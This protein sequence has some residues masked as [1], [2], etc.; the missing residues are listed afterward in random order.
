MNEELKVILTAEIDKLKQNLDKSKK[1]VQQFA[2][3]GVDKFKKFGEAAKKA[4]EA[5]KKG[6]KVIATAVTAAMAA[7]VALAASTEEFRAN[8]A[9]L[10]TAFETAGASAETAAQV[11]K[12]LYRV[13]GDD[14][15]AVEA[16]QH[17]AKLTNNQQ[18]LSEWTNICQGVYAT[19][20]ESLPIEGL[21]EAVNHTAKLGEV[22]GVLADALE[23]S[24]VNV[25]DFNAK[26][27]QCNTE[28]ER[29][30]LIRTTL[31]ELYDDAAENYEKN[32]AGILAN[33]EAQLRLNKAMAGLGEAFMPVQTALTNFTA[34]II[35][36]LTPAVQKLSE[37]YTPALEAT[38]MKV[39]DA[40]ADLVTWITENHHKFGEFIDVVRNI[41]GPLGK[42]ALTVTAGVW[43]FKGMVTVTSGVNA[44]LAYMAGGAAPK[45]IQSL[46]LV[47]DVISGGVTVALT[48]V[49]GAI[50]GFIAACGG[51]LPAIAVVVGILIALGAVIYGVVTNWDAIKAACISAWESIKTAVLNAW[52]FIQPYLAVF[53]DNILAGLQRMWEAVGPLWDS[54]VNLFA[55]AWN[56]IVAVWGMCEPFFAE[57]W[58]FIKV[59][60]TVVGAV[61]G[62]AFIVAWEAIVAVWGI[63]ADFFQV[64]A[65]TLSGIFAAIAAFIEGDFS[66][67]WE[68][69]KGIFASWGE[70]FQGL[71]DNIVG[72][73][74]GID[75]WLS[76][77]FGAAWESTKAYWVG[78]GEWFN[79]TVIQPVVSFFTALGTDISNV[80]STAL[81]S[82]QTIFQPIVDWFT[83]IV[84][85]VTGAFTGADTTIGG[86]FSAAYAGI[87]TAFS[88]ITNWFTNIVSAVT[89]AFSGA[90]STIS[91][92]FSAAWA[93]IQTAFSPITSWFQEKWDAVQALFKVGGISLPSIKLPHFSVSW[94]TDGFLGSVAE[95]L[96]LP[97]IPSLSVSWHAVG[98]V[99]D[100]PTLFSYGGG[101]HG[102]GENG[103]EAIVPL[104][105]NLAWLDKLAT[106]LNDRMGGDRPIYLQIDGKTFGQVT[107]DSINELTRQ[108]GSIP[109]IVG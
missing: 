27:A 81:T 14:G 23:W 51:V 89:G 85:S 42:A 54:I 52:N 20:G 78:V 18:H 94:S 2:K 29:E 87:T 37:K 66:G 86:I 21:T 31:N 38:L 47:K 32:S 6:L 44:I 83:N 96:G 106:M 35:E 59:A 16:A 53:W 99:F 60:A 36:T 19:F 11:Y 84:T 97:G 74:T 64:I 8:Q 28:A 26:L 33:R 108:R 22:Q 98:G 105:N 43:A 34:A 62:A 1:Q 95:F 50:G 82:I 92:V 109:L 90:D 45:F 71:W 67:A 40:F 46:T 103:A 104:E 79:T 63:A 102:L 68:A 4:G 61:L 69:V 101:L 30:A 107:C 55:Q 77:L 56:L 49:K 73:F 9:K 58:E 39:A 72:I 15:Q 48:A 93:G 13:L 75:S 10:E 88:P 7:M 76:G 70:F 91:G 12:G 65:D 41:L 3:D 17:L 24:G 80:F 5:V 25:D 57:L 100:K